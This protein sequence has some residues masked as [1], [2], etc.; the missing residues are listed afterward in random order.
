MTAKRFKPYTLEDDKTVKQ[1]KEWLS[2]FDDDCKV[3]TVLLKGD[4]R[5]IHLDAWTT[6]LELSFEVEE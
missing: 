2:N 6:G 3:K 4:A 1:W 5:Y